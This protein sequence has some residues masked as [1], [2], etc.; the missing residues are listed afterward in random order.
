[1]IGEHG[2]S[3]PVVQ[4]SVDILRN[5]IDILKLNLNCSKLSFSLRTTGLD[6]SN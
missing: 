1:M 6:I 5:L 4:G 3:V 2:M